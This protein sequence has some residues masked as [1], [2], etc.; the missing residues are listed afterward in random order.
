M[1][2]IAEEQ[3]LKVWSECRKR[4]DDETCYYLWVGMDHCPE[5]QIGEMCLLVK[6][7]EESHGDRD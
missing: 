2:D 1:R 3:K 4:R 6:E 7:A 5:Y